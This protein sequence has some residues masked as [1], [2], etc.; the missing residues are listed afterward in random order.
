[1]VVHGLREQGIVA[2]PRLGWVRASPHFYISPD[3]VER[4]IEAL[5]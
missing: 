5:P 2:A 3:E 1:M 4:M